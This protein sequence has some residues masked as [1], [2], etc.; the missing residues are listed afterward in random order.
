MTSRPRTIDA[1]AAGLL[2]LAAASASAACGPDALGTARTLTLA[3]AAAAY[4]TA[5]HAPLPLKPHEVVIT[6]DDGPDA[7]STP[8]V[9]R[10]LAEQCVRATFFMNGEQMLREPALVRRVLAEGHSAGMHGHRHPHFAQM[11]GPE[12]LADLAA[13]EAAWQKVLGGVAPAAWRFPF[14]E[15]TPVLLDAL[16]QRRVTV[17]SVDAGI[18]DWLP[19]Q[20]PALLAGRLLE[21]LERSGGGIVLLHDPQEQ[22]AAALP[23]LLSALKSAGYRVVHLEWQDQ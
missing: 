16:A 9:L 18:D 21:R 12:Q 19:R 14:L 22:T 5:Q 3:R 8:R 17:M 1:F 23:L 11:P 20:S 15:E 4:G 10:A 7:E 2:A 13:M 6:F